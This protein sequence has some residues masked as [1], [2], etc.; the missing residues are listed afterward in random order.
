MSLMLA[1]LFNTNILSS[2]VLNSNRHE[3]SQS[4]KTT[5]SNT[6]SNSQNSKSASG[7]VS[8]T[9]GNNKHRQISFVNNTKNKVNDDSSS[10]S[11]LSGVGRIRATP[12]LTI[13]AH[14]CTRLH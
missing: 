13:T 5:N 10:E 8:D 12:T 9:I 6:T 11:I 1:V 3:S 2:F 7:T 14:R 4:S